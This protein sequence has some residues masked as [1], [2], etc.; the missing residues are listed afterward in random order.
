MEKVETE[1]KNYKTI[2]YKGVEWKLVIMLVG[3]IAILLS[4]YFIS[5]TF[6][7]AVHESM[8]IGI[9]TLLVTLVMTVLI[10]MCIILAFGKEDDDDKSKLF[11]AVKIINGYR[12]GYVGYILEEGCFYPDTWTCHSGYDVRIN[13][14]G[15]PIDENCFSCYDGWVREEHVTPCL[16][17]KC[18][19]PLFSDLGNDTF[20][21]SKCKKKV[22]ILAYEEKND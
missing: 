9:I 21:C 3:V 19:L 2:E 20:V 14:Y 17:K 7:H 13:A 8:A 16:C 11:Q 5:R 22:K 15:C 12:K 1:Y 10:V 18:G 4:S 6:G